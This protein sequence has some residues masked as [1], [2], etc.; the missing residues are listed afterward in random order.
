MLRDR[1]DEELRAFPNQDQF[2]IEDQ[3]SQGLNC[4]RRATQCKVGSGAMDRF[5]VPVVTDPADDV[6][7]FRQTPAIDR[8]EDIGRI[9]VRCQHDRMGLVDA[10]RLDGFKVRRVANDYVICMT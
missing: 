9:I 7:V 3:R 6:G 10:C 5:E 2:L 8:E 1:L 4:E